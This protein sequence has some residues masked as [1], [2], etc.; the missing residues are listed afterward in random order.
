MFDPASN[1]LPEPEPDHFHVEVEGAFIFRIEVDDDGTVT[2]MA[3]VEES[4][5]HVT[6][7]RFPAKPH[8]RSIRKWFRAA[9]IRDVPRTQWG[10]TVEGGMFY[11][12]LSGTVVGTDDIPE[13]LEDRPDNMF[14]LENVTMRDLDLP[15]DYSSEPSAT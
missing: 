6:L 12:N 15:E 9:G 14:V 7:F 1:P 11:V 8:Q 2:V 13:G 3:A 10:G 4:E 5:K